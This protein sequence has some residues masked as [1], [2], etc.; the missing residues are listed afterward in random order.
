MENSEP[1]VSNMLTHAYHGPVTHESLATLEKKLITA[2]QSAKD[3][4]AAREKALENRLTKAEQLL[5]SG[6]KDIQT[7]VS[8]FQTILNTASANSWRTQAEATY[9]EG[10]TQAE[11]LQAT[12][13]DIQ[14]SLKESCTRLNQAATQVVKSTSK[15]LGNLH[16]NELSQ[17]VDLCNDEVKTTSQL[18][19]RQMVGV[20]RWFHWKNL[21][22]VFFLSALVTLSTGLYVN[23]EWPW[24][25]HKAVVKQRAAGQALLDT[26]YQLSQNDQQLVLTDMAKTNTTA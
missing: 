24:E 18:A 17:L 25:T 5:G 7:V 3:L 4:L 14:K 21:A 11:M 22:L 26:W 20:V 16:P 8:H 6:I 19:N 10:K 9:K 12:Q 15:V 1:I 13:V 2:A 23:A